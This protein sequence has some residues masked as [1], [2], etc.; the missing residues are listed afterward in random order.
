MTHKRL[1]RNK[2]IEIREK[3]MVDCMDDNITTHNKRRKGH[4]YRI[5]EDK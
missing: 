5:L 1:E 4:A 2:N 3:F